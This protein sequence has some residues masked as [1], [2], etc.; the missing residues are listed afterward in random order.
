MHH[1]GSKFKR[2]AFGKC[3]FIQCTFAVCEPLAW[4]GLPKEIR[5]CSEIETFKQNLDFFL[6]NLWISLVLWFNLDEFSWSILE[7]YQHSLWHCIVLVNLKLNC[8]KQTWWFLLKKKYRWVCQSKMSA[9]SFWP[10]WVKVKFDCQ[11]LGILTSVSEIG[12][13]G[14]HGNTSKTYYMQLIE[15]F[16]Y[17]QKLTM[18]QGSFYV[19]AWPMRGGSTS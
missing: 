11:E 4:N 13:L 15:C 6:S 2:K 19:W 7:C 17:H 14:C 5:L 10:L 1:E 3:A 18:N 16:W 12:K 9:I 8:Q